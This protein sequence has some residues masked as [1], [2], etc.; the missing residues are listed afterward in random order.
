L[1]CNSQL[2]EKIVEQGALPVLVLLAQNGK[3]RST[4]LCVRAL[5]NLAWDEKTRKKI[6]ESGALA[7]L[8]ALAMNSNNAETLQGCAQSLCYLS[9]FEP[10]CAHMVKEDVVK[11]LI[12]ICD[13]Q[14]T[15]S[16]VDPFTVPD[17]S[18][19]TDPNNAGSSSTQDT[20]ATEKKREESEW[21][22]GQLVA[23]TLRLLS[24]SPGGQEKMV[25]NRAVPLLCRLASSLDRS[26]NEN[27]TY[28]QGE[29][30]RAL[31][32]AIAFCN[33]AYEPQLRERLVDEGAVRSVCLLSYAPDVETQWRCAATLRYLA[34]SPNNRFRM[35]D[36]GAAKAL[37][38][39]ACNENSREETKRV[40]AA[41]LCSLSKSKSAISHIVAEGAVPT[42][43]KLSE[44]PDL[45]T[46]KS[47]ATALAKLSTASVSV[48]K[49]TVL[50]LI[51]MSKEAEE[52][53]KKDEGDAPSLKSATHGVL[54]M[55]QFMGGDQD[56]PP[57]PLPIREI[58]APGSTSLPSPSWVIVHRISP[59]KAG[60][61]MGGHQPPEPEPP[62]MTPIFHTSGDD[63]SNV[64]NESA[65]SSATF[66]PK[67]ELAPE[68][69][70]RAR[71]N[72]MDSVDGSSVR[73]SLSKL[74]PDAGGK[75]QQ[76]QAASTETLV[77][78]DQ[79]VQKMSVAEA[80][81]G[82]GTPAG[83]NVMLDFSAEEDG[84]GDM[85]GGQWMQNDETNDPA[86]DAAVQD[87]SAAAAN[88]SSMKDDVSVESA[89][90]LQP[91]LSLNTPA[92]DS[93][94]LLA[95]KESAVGQNDMGELNQ[96]PGSEKSAANNT[97]YARNDNLEGANWWQPATDA[98][99]IDAQG[100]VLLYGSKSLNALNPKAMRSKQK[101]ALRRN[102]KNGGIEPGTYMHGG[103]EQGFVD[104]KERVA[105][106]GLWC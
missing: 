47:C 33:L 16:W 78:E 90:S 67:V 15:A 89:S 4:L 49:G 58:D 28:N 64:D 44:T 6:V 25:D 56:P 75:Q 20:S 46:I 23:L 36:N 7:A 12:T 105:Q 88:T 52:A 99:R 65:T 76:D 96:A 87:T 91:G 79:E 17:S 92:D 42:L 1:T 60:A 62:V 5:C 10:N 2:R 51:T 24:W 77:L 26:G 57:P 3:E 68:Q 97:G 8:I 55:G 19:D 34:L 103:P 53:K 37:I 69:R 27:A 41:A 9:F 32:C 50:A 38:S 104:F 70:R 66:F 71:F 73:Y 61:G 81:S 29:Q 83:D 95:D 72:S 54:V 35:V 101:Q 102:Q 45:D 86:G 48:A 93:G 94:K 59:A 63:K 100:D 13:K 43:I 21:G 80:L 18:G 22:I 30:D 14:S 85:A 98:E 82:G 84:V 31:D 74:R 40:C 11:A 106:L 39:M